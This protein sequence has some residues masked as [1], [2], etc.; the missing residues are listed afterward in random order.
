MAASRDFN[1]FYNPS[2]D[3]GVSAYLHSRQHHSPVRYATGCHNSVR[4]SSWD[5]SEVHSS[6]RS[7]GLG[8]LSYH[9]LQEHVIIT[10][11]NSYTMSKSTNFHLVP[12]DTPLS[13][14]YA[15]VECVS[16]YHR[17]HASTLPKLVVGY[18]SMF[19][20]CDFS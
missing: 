17:S 15:L 7:F 3:W 12:M 6:L 4:C 18:Q 19:V 10:I 16:I 5:S 8:C 14:E 20:L 2:A 9:Q 13:E 1:T 11:G